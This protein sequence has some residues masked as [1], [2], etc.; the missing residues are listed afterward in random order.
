LIAET[1]AAD[2]SVMAY[3]KAHKLEGSRVCPSGSLGAGQEITYNEVSSA[4][5][6]ITQ[7]QKITNYQSGFK[8][9]G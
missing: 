8:L 6:S 3:F 7:F 9:T 2:G 5:G 4:S 1:S